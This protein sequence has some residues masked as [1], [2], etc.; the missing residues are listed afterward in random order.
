[1]K[2][3]QSAIESLQA[4]GVCPRLHVD[5]THQD[6][7]CPD[8]VREKWTERLVI[9]L[10][11]NYPLELEFTAVGVEANLA[12]GGYVTRCTFPWVAIYVVAERDSGRGRVFEQ[13]VPA[14]LRATLVPLGVDPKLT[15]ARDKDRSRGS[16]RRKRGQGVKEPVVFGLAAVEESS[17]EVGVEVEVQAE[18]EAEQQEVKTRRAMFTVID[19]GS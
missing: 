10:D 13:N 19:G 17:A 6:A 2:P 11:P 9:D 8:F 4:K 12:F 5:V 18:A 16:G 15:K 3:V 1:M 7:V 14:S